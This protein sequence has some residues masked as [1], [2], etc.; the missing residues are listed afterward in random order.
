MNQRWK[1]SRAKSERES[2]RSD[3]ALNDDN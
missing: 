1:R 2:L 3:D